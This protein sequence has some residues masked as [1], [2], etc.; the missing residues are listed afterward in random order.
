MIQEANHFYRAVNQDE[1]LYKHILSTIA[2]DFQYPNINRIWATLF[3]S[4]QGWGKTWI[5]HLLTHFNGWK[6][7]KWLEQE[8]IYDRYR[9]WIP[10]C[11]MV[12]ID[13]LAGKNQAKFVSKIKTLITSDSHRTEA[14]Y[15]NQ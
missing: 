7:T 9:D 13:E 12:I 14:K 1:F 5:G 3:C 6:N 15:K 10:T 11:N 2:H 4:T 8:E